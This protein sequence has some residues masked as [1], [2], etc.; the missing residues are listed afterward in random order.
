MYSVA[1]VSMESISLTVASPGVKELHAW[2][3]TSHS[4]PIACQGRSVEVVAKRRGRCSA[5]WGSS[6]LRVGADDLRFRVSSD[7]A[8]SSLLSSKR[9]ISVVCAA[10]CSASMRASSTRFVARSR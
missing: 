4:T 9:N 5:S 6:H 10:C 7:R 2:T 8:V 3:R 1:S